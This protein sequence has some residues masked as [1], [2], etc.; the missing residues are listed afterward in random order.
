MSRSTS[1]GDVSQPPGPEEDT[2]DMAELMN[3]NILE[4]G[5]TA[6][7][8]GKTDV[9]STWHFLSKLRV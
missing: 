6:T 8:R 1:R 4:A 3:G 2:V 7:N 5:N 9:V